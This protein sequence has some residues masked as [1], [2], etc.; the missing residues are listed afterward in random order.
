MPICR[1]G[2]A[3]YEAAPNRAL[4]DLY[5][6]HLR[7][8]ARDGQRVAKVAKDQFRGFDVFTAF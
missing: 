8:R 4:N 2:F 5:G 6:M 7:V 3:R 1:Y